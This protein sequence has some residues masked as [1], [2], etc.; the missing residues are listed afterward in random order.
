MVSPSGRLQFQAATV[1]EQVLDSLL[2][3]RTLGYEAITR[4][5]RPDVEACR[6][7]GGSVWLRK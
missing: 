7:G 2:D 4:T 1:A 6:Q 5:A 3:T